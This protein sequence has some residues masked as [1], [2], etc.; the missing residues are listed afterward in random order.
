[1]GFSPIVITKKALQ[2][3]YP[4]GLMTCFPVEKMEI[5]EDLYSSIEWYRLY[6]NPVTNKFYLRVYFKSECTF[7]NIEVSKEAYKE[8]FELFHNS[9]ECAPWQYRSKNIFDAYN[10]EVYSQFFTDVMN[11]LEK[12]VIGEYK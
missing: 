6:W 1:M 9:I 4:N 12:D 8:L 5:E 11:I 10:T 7:D 3:N 2:F